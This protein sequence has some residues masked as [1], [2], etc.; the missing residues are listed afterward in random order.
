MSADQNKPE[1]EPPKK[2]DEI[3]GYYDDM[4]KGEMEKHAPGIRKA[5]IALFVKGAE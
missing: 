5:R 4:R 3:S 2:E 1:P